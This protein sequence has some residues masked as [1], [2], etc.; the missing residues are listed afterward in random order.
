MK[1]T[2]LDESAKCTVILA[3]YGMASEALDIPTLNT[4]FMVTPRR[5]IEQSVGRILRAKT[6]IEPMI[7]DIVDQL[8]SF[9]S[10]GLYRRK[11]YKK[12]NYNMK[13]FTVDENEIIA[14]MD[15]TSDNSTVCTTNV[16][17]LEAKDLFID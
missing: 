17:D 3:S 14:E 12:L 4:L 15:L 1:Q 13:V 10:Q 6:E 5:S 7:V 9:N 16:E 11:F 2:K 8:P